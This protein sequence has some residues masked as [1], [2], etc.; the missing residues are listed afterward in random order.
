MKYQDTS[1][2]KP[3]MCEE[4]QER[5]EEMRKGLAPILPEDDS[6]LPEAT[7][8]TC[9]ECG[10]NFSLQVPGPWEPDGTMICRPCYLKARKVMVVPAKAEYREVTTANVLSMMDTVGINLRLHGHFTFEA[11][12]PCPSGSTM[13]E[14]MDQIASKGT[15]GFIRGVYIWGPTGTG[16]SQLSVSVVR[17]LMEMGILNARNVV[18]DR[19]RAMITQLQDRYSTGR[20]DEFSERR[21]RAKL[22]V[23]EDAGTE[24]LTTDAFRIVEDI[25]DA[26]EGHATIITSNLN[27][28]QLIEKWVDAASVERFRSR[29]ATYDPIQ[30]TGK[31]RRFG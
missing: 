6:V 30:L 13:Q 28:N 21:R 1:P 19:A 2:R 12:K 23:Y 22:W 3:T 11:L 25:I 20:V 4:L 17:K 14:F 15:M 10:N 8:Y 27:R 5:L 26:R 29:L 9:R 31:D 7:E 18:Y 16:K 24:K